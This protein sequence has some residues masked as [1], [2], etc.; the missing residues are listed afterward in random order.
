[1]SKNVNNDVRKDSPIRKRMF[2]N[3]CFS[4]KFSSLTHS[5]ALSHSRSL[6]YVA[7]VCSRKQHL[8]LYV[9]QGKKIHNLGSSPSWIVI[10]FFTS[11][12]VTMFYVRQINHTR[13]SYSRWRL[14]KN[15]KAKT[16]NY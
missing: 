2:R 5:T 10:T 12:L 14:P 9:S 8:N 4:L 11:C 7:W 6:C 16:I 15:L 1:M 3:T 13:F